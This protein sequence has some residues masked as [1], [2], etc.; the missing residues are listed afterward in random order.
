M[1]N[2]PHLISA[3]N[4]QEAARQIQLCYAEKHGVKLKR[5]TLLQ[6]LSQ[7][8]K[9]ANMN[10][11]Q[12]KQ[13]TVSIHKDI[14]C[15]IG[16]EYVGLEDSYDQPQ[17]QTHID[18]SEVG[19]KSQLMDSVIEDL[20]NTS[21]P[22][23]VKLLERLAHIDGWD[24]TQANLEEEVGV[25]CDSPWEW[26]SQDTVEFMEAVKDISFE[27]KEAL[28][29]S[30]VNSEN[31]TGG[32]ELICISEGV[33]PKAQIP[34]LEVYTSDDKHSARL[35]GVFSHNL[36]NPLNAKNV[37]QMVFDGM[38][39][40]QQSVP[41]FEDRTIGDDL[42]VTF[43]V[44]PTHKATNG[45]TVAIKV[46]VQYEGDKPWDDSFTEHFVNNSI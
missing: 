13:G 26:S 15:W 40:F 33:E 38:P 44:V 35:Q 30:I 3:N 5:S 28:F 6:G 24:D 23:L 31:V 45:C 27:H 37:I 14:P 8:L 12:A 21:N 32:W 22:D 20:I 39:E 36:A 4:A 2:Y 29:D 25:S 41:S 16:I 17:I 10:T 11:M 34:L 43:E 18:F 1:N 42:R 19:A 7:A 9:Y 46:V